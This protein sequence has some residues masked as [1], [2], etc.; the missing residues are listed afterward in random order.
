MN[1][2]EI[3]EQSKKHSGLKFNEKGFR[4]A[5]GLPLTGQTKLLNQLINDGIVAK[6]GNSFT[7]L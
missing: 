3:K 4:Y 1:Y 2:E 7:V 6:D 5:F